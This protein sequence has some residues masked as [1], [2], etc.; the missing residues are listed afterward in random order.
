MVNNNGHPLHGPIHRHANR[1]CD[2]GHKREEVLAGEI[3][4]PPAHHHAQR[5]PLAS[6]A[7]ASG[8]VVGLA[9]DV[10]VIPTLHDIV[11]VPSGY[12]NSDIYMI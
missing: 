5:S 12:I 8:G 10:G 3:A 4:T 2:R 9:G 7:M 11:I 1:V 6:P